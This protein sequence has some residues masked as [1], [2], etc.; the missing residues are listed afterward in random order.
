M[1]KKRLYFIL[2]LFMSLISFFSCNKNETTNDNISEPR[3]SALE[4]SNISPTSVMLSASIIDNGGSPVI[5]R[6][7]RLSKNSSIKAN[8]NWEID[9]DCSSGTDNF[10]C[11]ISG[12]E[13]N[14]TYYYIEISC[15]FLL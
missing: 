4:V 6:G 5:K 3:I 15:I 14:T 9:N 7:F 10:S 12:L 13:E 2:F 1:I 8:D 11:T